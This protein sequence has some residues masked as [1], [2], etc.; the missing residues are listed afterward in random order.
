MIYKKVLK[1]IFVWHIKC[2]ANMSTANIWLII[3]D[4]RSKWK[5]KLA[6]KAYSLSIFK[7][8]S[9]CYTFLTASSIFKQLYMLKNL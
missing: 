8:Y 4:T 6:Y 5:G 1:L 9:E 7:A 3:F 2:L